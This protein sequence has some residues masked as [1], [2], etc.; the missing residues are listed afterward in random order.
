MNTNI[1]HD[2]FMGADIVF[3][4]VPVVPEG[5]KGRQLTAAV[6]SRQRGRWSLCSSARTF[7]RPSLSRRLTRAEG[8]GER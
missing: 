5:N 6:V 4:P 7:L 8:L 1:W 3:I 2:F